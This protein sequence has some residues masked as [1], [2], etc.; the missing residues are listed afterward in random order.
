[1]TKQI[2]LL[3]LLPLLLAM[4]HSAAA[5]SISGTLTADNAFYVYISTSDTTLGMLLSSGTLNANSTFN[6]A[7]SPGTNYLH[8]E[9]INTFYEAGLL[10]EFSL[11]GTGAH[12]MNGS[13]TLF[14]DTADWLGGFNDG[15]S[16]LSSPQPWVV[17]NGAV[18]S[19]GTVGVWGNFINPSAV[20]I[21]P[22]DAIS[23][24]IPGNGGLGVCQYC[25]VDFSTPIFTPASTAAPEPGSL[26]LLGAGLA[27]AVIRRKLLL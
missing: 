21:W 20:W 5:T 1:M 10:G 12:F 13:Q 9:A 15:N 19:F 26:A 25:T 24:P 3:A 22:G 7:L 2:R 23:F 18:I 14:T 6:A 16:D 27:S 8:I 17:P 11:T 4:S